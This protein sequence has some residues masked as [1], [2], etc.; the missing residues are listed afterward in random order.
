VCIETKGDLPGSGKLGCGDRVGTM[1]NENKIRELKLYSK[2]STVLGSFS[3][4]LALA[5]ER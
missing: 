4:R 3:T 1:R 5:G 2:G